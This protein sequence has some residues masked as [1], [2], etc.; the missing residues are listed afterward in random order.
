MLSTLSY[1]SASLLV[2]FPFQSWNHPH[3][4]LVYPFLSL[5]CPLLSKRPRLSPQTPGEVW[6]T[7]V[8]TVSWMS[9]CLRSGMSSGLDPVLPW[10]SSRLFRLA[11]LVL[12][13]LWPLPL[14]V[15]L[16]FCHLQL[17]AMHGVFVIWGFRS[18]TVQC[19]CITLHFAIWNSIPHFATHLTSTC[20]SVCLH[21]LAQFGDLRQPNL[22][23]VGIK[24]NG[25]I[26]KGNF[27]FGVLKQF[28]TT[29]QGS[30]LFSLR[31]KMS[32]ITITVCE[33]FKKNVRMCQ[34]NRMST[35]IVSS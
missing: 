1:L 9:P 32:Q 27:R 33:R 35:T 5:L 13:S 6:H 30:I 2:W 11:A 18:Y 21:F 14:Y 7:V 4:C 15:F 3:C 25:N 31:S 10:L 34:S 19:T 28:G 22:S 17:L 26:K 12:Y 29:W 23:E 16:L 24:V 20:L 8:H